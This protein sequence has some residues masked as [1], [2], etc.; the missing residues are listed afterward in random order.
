A[1]AAA[2]SAR[3]PGSAAP[4]MIASRG[5]MRLLGID[6]LGL[7]QRQAQALAPLG[8]RILRFDLVDGGADHHLLTGLHSMVV[9]DD[10]RDR[11]AGYG[12][13][14]LDDQLGLAGGQR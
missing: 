5:S 1:T 6:S 14:Q 11:I 3:C 9:V 12:I 7:V 4:R 8:T 13:A 2:T 10:A